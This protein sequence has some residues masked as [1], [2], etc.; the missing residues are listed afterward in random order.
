M[1]LHVDRIQLDRRKAVIRGD[2]SLVV[3]ATLTRAGVLTYY[4]R[5]GK[6][7]RRL[8]HADDVLSPDRVAAM[9]GLPVTLNHPP[10]MVTTDNASRYTVGTVDLSTR[11]EGNLAAGT[12]VLHDKRAIDAVMSGSHSEISPGYWA[13]ILP[14][15]GNYDGEAYDDRQ[16]NQRW[17]H[18]ALV[19]K[20]RSGPDVRVM[21]DSGNDCHIDGCGNGQQPCAWME[22]P[23]SEKPQ[24]DTTTT[25]GNGWAVLVLDNE[26]IKLRPGQAK[27]VTDALAAKDAEIAKLRDEVSAA[28]GRGD[29]AEQA[30]KDAEDKHKKALDAAKA[31]AEARAMRVAT[32]RAEHR[33]FTGADAQ[34][35]ADDTAMQSAVIKHLSPGFNLDGREPV[36]IA[37]IY[38]YVTEQA[39]AAA[40]GDADLRS[41]LDHIPGDTKSDTTVAAAGR[42]F[43]AAAKR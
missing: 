23:M 41:A 16:V 17:N 24:N 40:K 15:S 19:E 6:P 5:N 32:L 28:K 3:P 29:A 34:S 31:E 11:R 10:E 4:D 43:D 1:N 33:E 12:L 30:V 14:E 8:R 36:A 37:S 22:V 35:D 20:G 2:G 26:E 39:R 13:D 9:G 42:L 21:L 7:K 38:Q 18:V 25:A 27:A